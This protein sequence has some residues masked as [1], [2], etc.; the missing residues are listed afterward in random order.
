MALFALP[1]RLMSRRSSGLSRLSLS[2]AWRYLPGSDESAEAYERRRQQRECDLE[3]ESNLSGRSK[4]LTLPI[5]WML[6][7]VSCFWKEPNCNANA[8]HKDNELATNVAVHAHFICPRSAAGNE[9]RHDLL[10]VY[11]DEMIAAD[12]PSDDTI[13]LW[14]LNETGQDPMSDGDVYAWTT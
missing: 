9:A 14:I 5:L 4:T 2:F 1:L 3:L 12:P 13:R 11:D 10:L 6:W 8:Q 7:L